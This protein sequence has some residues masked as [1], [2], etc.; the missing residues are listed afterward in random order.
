[1]V[2]HEGRGRHCKCSFE[3][4]E[5]ISDSG[6]DKANIPLDVGSK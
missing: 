1:M 2:Q 3:E 6:K 4:A 5:R